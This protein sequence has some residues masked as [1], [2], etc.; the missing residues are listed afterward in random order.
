MSFD[1]SINSAIFNGSNLS[2]FLITGFLIGIFSNIC[3]SILFLTTSSFS[4]G[5]FTFSFDFSIFGFSTGW[6]I[7]STFFSSTFFS[8]FSSCF[9]LTFGTLVF[10]EISINSTCT[11][12]GISKSGLL[13]IGNVT[14]AII[15]MAMWSK[16]ELK[17]D[18]LITYKH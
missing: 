10:S 7:F 5:S 18:D 1:L 6:L 17:I 16:I 12:G 14:I 13:N 11:I 15:K 4:D 2:F 3:C 8:F 9:L